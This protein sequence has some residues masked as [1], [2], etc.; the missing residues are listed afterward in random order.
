MTSQRTLNRLFVLHSWAG[1]VTGLLMFIV[2]FSGAVVVFKNEIDLWANPSLAQLPR[3]DKPASLDAVL[4]QLQTRYPGATVETIAL[5]DAINPSYFAF[6]RERGA[7]A[8]TRTKVALRSDTGTVVGPVDSQLGQYLRMLHVFLFFGPRWIVGFLGVAML[9]LIA[10]GIVIHRK[11]LAEL[12]TQRWGRSFRVVMSD[13]H[14]SAGIWGLGFHILIA[15]TGA[16]MGLAPLFEQGTKYVTTSANA[17]APKPARKVAS[18]T[19]APVPMQSL[20]ALYAT[21]QQAV[22]RLEARYVSLR[23][24][25]TDTAEASFTGNLSGHLVSTARVDINAA[26]GAPKKVHDPRTAGFWSLVNG[27]MEPLHFGDFGG[28]A[29]KWLYFFLGMTP[30][31]LSIS[32]TLI[33]LDARQQRRREAEATQGLST[34]GAA[35]AG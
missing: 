27:L 28:L 14:K 20:D 26:T 32:G 13:L 12:F 18:E 7:P 25:G 2:C 24:W 15:T 17:A 33:W 3:S 29:L 23:R 1:I 19:A 5:P 10:T 9:V 31:F 4:T 6:V 21:A 8:S 11:I 22:P 30:A 34:N 35:A 16:W